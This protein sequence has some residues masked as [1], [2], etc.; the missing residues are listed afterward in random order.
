MNMYFLL[1]DVAKYQID[2]KALLL[3]SNRK[4]V[5]KQ[6]CHSNQPSNEFIEETSNSLK[7]CFHCMLQISRS[8]DIN[9]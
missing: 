2:F 9:F 3:T 4:Y 5:I 8:K 1:E 6:A 7:I